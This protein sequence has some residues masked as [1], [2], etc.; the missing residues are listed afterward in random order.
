[1]ALQKLLDEPKG[2]TT[3][4]PRQAFLL[5]VFWEA[6]NQS[7][8]DKVLDAL[9]RCSKATCRDTPCVPTYYFRRS[10]L[11]A[12]LIHEK[13]LTVGDHPQLRDALK[14]MKVGVPKPAIQADLVRR[15]LNPDLLDMD[16]A[17]PLP[18]AM[19]QTPVILEFTELYLDERSFYE[20]AG[21]KEYLA[22][23]GEVIAPGLHNRQTTVRLGYPTAEIRDRILAPM[24]KEQVEPLQ[25]RCVLWRRPPVKPQSPTLLSMD[26]PGAAK[27]AMEILP[28]SLHQLSTTLVAFPHPLREGRV[29]VLAILPLL[30]DRRL[31]Q[32]LANVTLNGIEVHCD[33]SHLDIV[34]ND[35]A[36]VDFRCLHVVQEVKCGYLIHDKAETVD[37]INDQSGLKSGT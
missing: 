28:D 4:Y 9:Q 23:Y 27:H 29:R 2:K 15:G 8:A 10:A 16:P 22:A 36:L 37:E 3:Y 34:Q 32:E 12:S 14:R 18:Q 26:V 6:P 35:M 13:P 7:A 21:S 20:H 1:M 31:F 33:K 5:H 17:T 25:D 30:P 24:L 11:D 19:Q